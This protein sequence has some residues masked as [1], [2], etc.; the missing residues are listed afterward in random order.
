MKKKRIHHLIVMD[1]S[2]VVGVL[3][4]RDAGGRS[5]AGVRQR[6]LVAELMSP[7]VVSLDPDATV[8]KAA[9]LMRGRTIGCIPVIDG[10]R[11]VGIVTV[12]DLLE[13]VGRGGD[14]RVPVQRAALHYRV[15]HRKQRRAGGSW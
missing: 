9:N 12:S 5:G 15:P 3:S 8:R 7:H 11:L 10:R 6:A 13:I 1:G 14:R 2:D 4:D